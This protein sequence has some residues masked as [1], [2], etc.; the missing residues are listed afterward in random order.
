MSF[1]TSENLSAKVAEVIQELGDAG[2]SQAWAVAD[3]LNTI[4][5]NGGI[6]STDGHL[7]VCAEEII[8]AAQRFIDEVQ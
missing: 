8:K 2:D 4:A 6:Q 5:E 7:I 1:D 3:C